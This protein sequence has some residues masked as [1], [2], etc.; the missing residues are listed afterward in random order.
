VRELSAVVLVGGCALDFEA[1]G[2]IMRRLAQDGVVAGCAQVRGTMG[3]R[4][5]VATGLVLAH[6]ADHGR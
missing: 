4:N 2:M 5:A 1:P 6:G 3:P